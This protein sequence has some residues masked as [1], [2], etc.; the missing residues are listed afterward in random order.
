MHDVKTVLCD[1][2]GVV[3]GID[4]GRA[5]QCW[6]K[7]CKLSS[8][9]I[10]TRFQFDE[11]YKRHER[12]EIGASEYFAHLRATLAIEGTDR[13]IA[14]GWNAIFTGELVES[15]E[16][17]RGAATRVSCYGFSNSNPTHHAYWLAAYP[18]V[19]AL[20]REI[21]VS[22]DLGMRKP[23]RNAFK[24]VADAIG[25]APESILFLDDTLENVAGAKDAGLH[26]M[27]VRT[28]ADVRSAL[29]RIGAL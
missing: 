5:F 24:M 12:R 29:A 17:I 27:H 21:F 23:E 20:F 4:F 15:V 10:R 28:P 11:A 6:S 25:E 3:I 18:N 22:S 26:A 1:L 7:G 13:E 8:E 19:A 16:Y 2:G 9:Q 14:D